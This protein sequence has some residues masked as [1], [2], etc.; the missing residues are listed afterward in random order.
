M[1]YYRKL[2][3]DWGK[4]KEIKFINFKINE[5]FF[6]GNMDVILTYDNAYEYGHAV[7]KILLSKENGVMRI[8]GYNVQSNDLLR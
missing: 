2:E 6:S 4:Y 8:S 7:E 3:V 5:N 1:K